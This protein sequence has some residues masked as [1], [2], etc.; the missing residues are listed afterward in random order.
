M[1][2]H[3]NFYL[4]FIIV[5]ILNSLLLFVNKRYENIIERYNNY[6]PSKYKI[7]RLILLLIFLAVIFAFYKLMFT[8]S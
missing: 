2:E 1:N 7:T 5:I 3:I 8:T 6:N 4:I